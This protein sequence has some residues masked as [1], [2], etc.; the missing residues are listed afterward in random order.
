[1]PTTTTTTEAALEE[2]DYATETDDENLP[3][4]RVYEDSWAAA[5]IFFVSFAPLMRYIPF[6]ASSFRI[7]NKFLEQLS[8]LEE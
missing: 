4:C 2:E 5:I 3:Y 7:L 8:L 1:M 6:S